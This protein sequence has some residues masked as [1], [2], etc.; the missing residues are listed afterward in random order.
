MQA[1]PSRALRRRVF[2]ALLCLLLLLS[3]VPASRADA[4]TW[5]S[6]T[7][8]TEAIY[9]DLGDLQVQ[10]WPDFYDFLARLP[11][12]QQV[13]MY[14]TRTDW[15]I[16]NELHE[17]FPN[18]EFGLTLRIGKHRLRTDATAFST[19]YYEGDPTVS[20]DEMAQVRFCKHLYALD[21]GHNRIRDL[22]FLY[23]LPELRVLIVALCQLTDI[24][25]IG[26]L[27]H[28]EYLE[29]FHNKIEDLSP[30]ADM[31]YL[32]DLNIV[33]NE[34]TDLSPLRHLTSLK[35]LCIHEYRYHGSHKTD[36]DMLADLQA[37]LP[38]CHIDATSTS[39]GGGWRNHPHY[40]VIKRMFKKQVYEPFEDS[41]P[42]NLPEGL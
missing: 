2:S 34:V 26:S 15:K 14:N 28:L 32:M 8:D 22:S 35:R 6:L 41:D 3:A 40:D 30:L 42:A 12:L 17:R 7:V 29:L 20:Q 37:A 1:I 9:L 4:V 21:L 31:P 23:E 16:V 24:T 39:T 18:I 11:A 10:N 19:L 36:P 5:R 13:D 38:D 27:H 25:P 33:R